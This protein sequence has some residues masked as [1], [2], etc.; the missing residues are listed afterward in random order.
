M[1]A[2]KVVEIAVIAAVLSSPQAEEQPLP[3]YKDPS[4]SVDGRVGDLAKR[5]NLDEKANQLVLPFGAK[6]PQDYAGVQQIGTRWLLSTPFPA[7]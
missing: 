4:A 5:M 1:R 6:Y 3:L 7:R 2:Q